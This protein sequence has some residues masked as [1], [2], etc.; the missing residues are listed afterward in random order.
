M[1]GLSA[2]TYSCGGEGSR[3]GLG[4]VFSL[5]SKAGFLSTLWKNFRMPCRSSNWMSDSSPEGGSEREEMDDNSEE[6]SSAI[7]DWLTRVLVDGRLLRLKHG[8]RG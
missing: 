3:L 7:L 2:S 5:G 8:K 4:G 6:S 1:S